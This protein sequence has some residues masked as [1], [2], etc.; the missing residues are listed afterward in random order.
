MIPLRRRRQREAELV[1][2]CE[3]FLAGRYAERLAE[4]ASR[5][6]GWAWLN[7]VAHGTGA[8]LAS[9]RQNRRS[10]GSML[11]HWHW[12]AAR[13]YLIGEVLDAVDAGRGSL[14]VLQQRVL[15]PLES[16]LG[17]DPVGVRF[18]RDLVR[19]ALLALEADEQ[20]RRGRSQR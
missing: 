18:P 20:A 7:L 19:R 14:P 11:P 4:R 9:A 17:A 13:A 12:V 15:R 8:D 5:V 3:A 6:P 10:A 1:A 16:Q 2:D